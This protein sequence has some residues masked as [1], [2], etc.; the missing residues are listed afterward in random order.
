MQEQNAN[1]NTETLKEKKSS[2]NLAAIMTKVDAAGETG[3]KKVLPNMPFL[4]FLVLLAAVHIANSHLAEN[5][6]RN[7]TKAEKEVKNL[8][9]QYMTTTS[10]LMQKSKQSEV[11]KLVKTQGLKELRIPPYKITV[12]E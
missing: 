6:A 8:R 9:W 10:G 1:S 5:Y 11:A 2:K 7:I 12:K 3:M 4:F